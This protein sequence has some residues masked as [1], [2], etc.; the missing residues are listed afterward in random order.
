ML[1]LQFLLSDGFSFDA[2]LKVEPAKTSHSDLLVHKL[3]M[4]QFAALLQCESSPTSES[5]LVKQEINM[6]LL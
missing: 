1:R 5:L 3:P 6:L 2:V 4:E